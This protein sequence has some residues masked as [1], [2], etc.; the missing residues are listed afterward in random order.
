ML[1]RKEEKDPRKCIE[2][3]K[4]VTTCSL[5]FFRQL[6]KTCFDEFKQYAN[7]LEKSSQDMEYK[8]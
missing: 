7:C 1:C 2:D 6:K 5:N 3:G 4:A 8:Q